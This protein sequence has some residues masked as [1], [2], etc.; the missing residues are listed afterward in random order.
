MNSIGWLPALLQE[1]CRFHQTIRC[2]LFIHSSHNW[3]LQPDI[4]SDYPTV[5]PDNCNFTKHESKNNSISEDIE[6]HV[7]G[8]KEEW[9]KAKPDIFRKP[10]EEHEGGP[11]GPYDQNPAGSLHMLCKQFDG[12]SV[13]W[14]KTHE[15]AARQTYEKNARMIHE[16]F[17]L[18]ETGLCLNSKYPHLGASPDDLY[19]ASVVGK[20][21]SK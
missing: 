13:W 4:Q 5:R 8:L 1:P 12:P 20:V 15:R 10:S 2:F 9:A 3:K 19:H 14:G 16:H 18:D 11:S 6:R 7:S 17:K 21:F